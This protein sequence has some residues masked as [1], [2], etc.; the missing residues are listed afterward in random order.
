MT[1]KD[2]KNYRMNDICRFCEEISIDRVKDHCHLTGI[3]GGKT[4][5]KININFAK[6]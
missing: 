3:Y 1:E 4:H 6:K 5:N 2:E